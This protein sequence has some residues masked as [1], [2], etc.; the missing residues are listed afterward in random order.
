[1]PEGWTEAEVAQ[2]GVSR[3]DV[4]RH[5]YQA[6]DPTWLPYAK[7]T[8]LTALDRTPLPSVLAEGGESQRA[9]VAA[10]AVAR[11][12]LP[13]D[14]M[15]VV[16][17]R[18]ADSVAFG[19][20]L[21]RFAREPVALVPTFNNWPAKN[22]LVP[23]QE[24]L[25]ALATMLPQA[26]DGSRPGRSRPVFLLDS[27]RLA[28]REDEPDDEVYDNRYALA[29]T[30]FPEPAALL[31]QGIRRVLYLVP[32]R[33]EAR[34]EED[35]LH[36]TFLAYAQAGIAIALVDLDDLM[37]VQPVQGVAEEEYAGDWEEVFVDY[38][39]D[40]VP[41]VTVVGSTG[42]YRRAHGGFGGVRAAP[43]VLPAAVTSG[44]HGSHGF[45]GGHGGGHGGGG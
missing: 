31:A 15:W 1:M 4:L 29:Q 23:A 7:Y 37:G 11:D 17:L 44:S 35:D 22:E 30:D 42:F 25:G 28:Y 10:T 34:S 9:A 33:Q 36:A 14:V 26:L 3:D 13:A 39:L 12:G 19:T 8:L 45:G 5:W 27:W 41:R 40:I 18:G 38:P 21:S 32:S 20:T 16:D 43:H 24:T 2:R 6:A